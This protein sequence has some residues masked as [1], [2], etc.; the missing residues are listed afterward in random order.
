MHSPRR[1]SMASLFARISSILLLIREMASERAT[2]SLA[3]C[4]SDSAACDLTATNLLSVPSKSM[5]RQLAHSSRNSRSS[6]CKASNR[7]A[8]WRCRSSKALQQ[9]TSTALAAVLSSA[10]SDNSLKCW[11]TTAICSLISFRRAVSDGNPED[12]LSLVTA[13]S[14]R[15]SSNDSDNSLK[16][17]LTSSMQTSRK[18]VCA[19]S[20]SARSFHKGVKAAFFAELFSACMFRDRLLNS[21]CCFSNFAIMAAIICCWRWSVARPCGPASVG[22]VSLGAW[23]GGRKNAFCACFRSMAASFMKPSLISSKKLCACFL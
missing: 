13:A 15:L 3:I 8:A 12:A 21:S 18:C 23:P 9:S 20:C 22:S 2:C 7:F 14:T 6:V 16:A 5:L 17:R 11:C 10:R 4:S 1:L 19:I